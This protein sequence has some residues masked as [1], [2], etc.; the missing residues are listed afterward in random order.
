MD[1]TQIFKLKE[2]L[3]QANINYSFIPR[4]EQGGYQIILYNKT[5]TSRL[6]DGVTHRFSYGNNKGLIEI[7]GALTLE[8]YEGDRVLGYLT[9]DE[10]FER[11]NY[12]YENDT[13][14]YFCK[15]SKL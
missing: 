3:H 4:I 15:V 13:D 7:M 14:I 8:E 2:M 12:C 11:F 5:D 10:V 6:A 1:F 9:A